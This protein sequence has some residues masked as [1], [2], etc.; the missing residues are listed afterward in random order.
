[1]YYWLT[2]YT[3]FKTLDWPVWAHLGNLLQ[4][5]AQMPSYLGHTYV[6][7]LSLEAS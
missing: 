5:M 3:S 6:A 4:V 7:S 1:M 2:S